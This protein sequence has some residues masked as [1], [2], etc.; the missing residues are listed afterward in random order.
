MRKKI[1]TSKKK[2]SK[3]SAVFRYNTKM[4]GNQHSVYDPSSTISKAPYRWNPV[5]FVET[6]RIV[7]S[8]KS[9]RRN[10]SF[11]IL[12]HFRPG[13]EVYTIVH[14]GFG[15]KIIKD[16]IDE[17]HSFGV[18]TGTLKEY[19]LRQSRASSGIEADDIY[20]SYNEAKFFQFYRL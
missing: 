17:I 18:K 11:G 9:V 5:R 16:R 14:S 7:E 19:W 13:D 15:T 6:Y 10:N 1:V 4:F 12:P 8:S 20:S 2:K 3:P